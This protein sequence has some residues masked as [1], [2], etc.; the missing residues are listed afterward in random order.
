MENMLKKL[1]ALEKAKDEDKVNKDS[2]EEFDWFDY[3]DEEFEDDWDWKDDEDNEK[4][5]GQ[6]WDDNED[7][8]FDEN[9]WENYFEDWYKR[10]DMIFK[11]MKA[12]MTNAKL[13]LKEHLTNLAKLKSLENKLK[14]LMKEK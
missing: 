6:Y 13:P 9:Y 3:Y 5:L 1:D 14:S 7:W 10:Y 4:G 11:A 2:D 8:D 12:K